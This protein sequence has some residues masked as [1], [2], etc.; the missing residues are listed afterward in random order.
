ME[1][2][3]KTFENEWVRLEPIN[4]SAEFRK[5]LKHSSIVDNFWKWMPRLTGSG[6]T[7]DM[8]YEDALKKHKDGLMMSVAAYCQKDGS[9][10]GGASFLRMN[11]TH[12]RLQIDYVW[13]PENKRGT[14]VSLAIQTAMLRG[15]I[16]WRAKR[17]YWVVDITNEPMMKFVGEK[18]GAKKEGVIECYARMID[19]RWS[20]SAVFALVGDNIQAGIDRIEAK[21]RLEFP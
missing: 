15:A 4:P 14:S 10:V 6:T 19:G 20:D 7:F 1:L 11:R 9:F 16:A 8:Y 21:L 12:R 3:E 18:I 13:T 17:V 5:M 2:Y